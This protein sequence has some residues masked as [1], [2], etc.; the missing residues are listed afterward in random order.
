VSRILILLMFV[1]WL[2]WKPE[3]HVASPLGPAS[4][5]ALFLGGYAL[6]VLGTAGWSRQ[7]LGGITRPNLHRRLNRF[8]RVM[9]C[10]RLFIPLWFLVGMFALGWPE[11]VDRLLR[12]S[13][14]DLS[15][16][17]VGVTLGTLPAFAAWAGLW[18]SQYP[19]EIAF[20]EQA[21]ESQ[22][23]ADLPVHKSPGFRTYF[24]THLRLQ[25][26]FMVVPVLLI[27]MLHDALRLAATIALGPHSS[28]AGA[29][30]ADPEN[31]VTWL[32][33]A[34][35]V[36]A[37]APEI[38]RRVLHTEPLPNSPLRRRLESLC[39]RTG[40]RYREILLWRTQH[41][42]GNAAVMGF[43]PQ[44]RYIL[45][46]DLLLETMSDEE[47]EA[48]FAHELGHVV[49]RHMMWLVV[50][51]AMLTLFVMGGST[52]ISQWMDR[53]GLAG[54]PA[55]GIVI[56]TVYLLKF[57]LLFGFV[58]R[59]F[60]RQ[61]D[62]F[63]ARTMELS[64]AGVPNTAAS[65]I[66]LA[67][68]QLALATDGP[69]GAAASVSPFAL[70]FRASADPGHVG[71]YGA[72]VFGAALQRVAIVNNIPV[73]ARSWCHGSIAGRMQYLRNLSH[74]PARTA[75]FDRLMLLLYGSLLFALFA[76]A[77]FCWAAN[78]PP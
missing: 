4:A 11:M 13:G 51:F 71:R 5:L 20:R 1:F 34:V 17:L 28:P 8:N 6:L 58:S 39:R 61:A 10:A 73:K 52:W 66:L 25:L 64:R 31:P 26:L 56:A 59:R 24:L 67:A 68:R 29:A 41:N 9:V 37:F 60:E 76:G 42:V 40:V 22:L 48:V 19:A 14:T 2:A 38:L 35:L 57:L 53:F 32:V 62:V 3:Y 47:I 70:R 54:G 55:E 18:W 46:S 72:H 33:A 50:F 65:E 43:V 74:D 16:T 23:D 49:H 78:A 77:A 36:F 44:L 15:Q 27:A 12:L 30:L 7:F 45:L 63:A 75:R 21:L 69:G